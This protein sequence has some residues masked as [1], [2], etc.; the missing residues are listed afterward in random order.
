MTCSHLQGMSNGARL[1][2]RSTF[3]R[4]RSNPYRLSPF[5]L[6]RPMRL[7][8][9]YAIL[10]IVVPACGSSPAPTT[11]STPPTI[12]SVTLNANLASLMSA[13]QTTQ[14]TAIASFSN[15]TTQDVTNACTNWLTDNARVLTVNSTGLLTAQA[16]GTAT[17][18]ATC[19]AVVGRGAMTVALKQAALSTVSLSGTVTDGFSR[20]V[21]PNIAVQI[22]DGPNAGKGTK[23]DPAGSYLF[24]DLVP[25]A[26]TVTMSAVRYITTT[27]SVTLAADSRLDVVLNRNDAFPIDG[28]YNYTLVVQSPAWCLTHAFFSGPCSG[29]VGDWVTSNFSFD[30]QLVVEG[31]GARFRFILPSNTYPPWGGYSTF[32]FQ[33]TGTHLDGTIFASTPLSPVMFTAR[34]TPVI[35]ASMRADVFSGETDN[36]GRFRG[37]FDGQMDLWKLGMPCD[38][39]FACPTSGFTWTLTPH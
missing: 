33:R 5:P 18:T 13:G 26:F 32:A 1:A 12:Q 10:A 6:G 2:D 7:V 17:I 4:S 15:G 27:R 22:G 8:A 23:T 11:P 38:V 25:G 19:Q 30:G 29:G 9:G 14:A 28:T 21:L 20:G 16:S 31:D 3:M 39:T 36:A 24:P 35:S 34:G 37:I